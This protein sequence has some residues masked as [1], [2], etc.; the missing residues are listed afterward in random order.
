MRAVIPLLYTFVQ[1]ITRLPPA[2]DTSRISR[3]SCYFGTGGNRMAANKLTMKLT[4]EQQK[5]IREATGKSI[6]EL[7]IDLAS[8]GHLTEGE[9]EQ[10]AGGGWDI[11]AN[12]KI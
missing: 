2:A 5:Q 3:K 1:E 4:D 9:L 7:N 12:Q 8:K 10:V 6:A 11:K